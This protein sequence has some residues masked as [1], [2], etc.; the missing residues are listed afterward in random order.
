MYGNLRQTKKLCKRLR[1]PL[2]PKGTILHGDP[3]LRNFM[4]NDSKLT[5][6]IDGNAKL[7]I[8]IEEI[9]KVWVFL[10][11]YSRIHGLKQELLFKKFL[12]GYRKNIDEFSY[13]DLFDLFVIKKL[14]SG[15]D[16][17]FRMEKNEEVKYYIK[18]LTRFLSKMEK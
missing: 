17:A 9:A 7:G 14:V 11:L 15:L 18:T 12:K 5:A 10:G 4:F 3:S 13:N 16:T 6:V 2:I 8:P 1:I